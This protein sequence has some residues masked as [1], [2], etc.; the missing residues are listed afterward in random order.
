MA[1]NKTKIIHKAEI[2]IIINKKNTVNRV[3][4]KN[5]ILLIPLNNNKQ[6]KKATEASSNPLPKPVRIIIKIDKKSI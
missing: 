2:L 6:I 5:S 3:M 4:N 1:N